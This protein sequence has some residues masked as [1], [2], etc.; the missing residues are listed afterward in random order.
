MS[1]I[2]RD[3]IFSTNKQKQRERSTTSP[4]AWFHYL[5]LLAANRLVIC[6][7]LPL[8]IAAICCYLSLVVI[9]CRYLPLTLSKISSPK[10][11][12]KCMLYYVFPTCPIIFKACG[13][14]GSTAE[15]LSLWFRHKKHSWVLERAPPRFSSCSL[16]GVLGMVFV[17][18]DFVF[19][20]VWDPSNHIWVLISFNS[21]YKLV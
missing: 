11:L 14:C 10:G 3:I 18:F 13:G 19:F 12:P 9:N 20:E 7:Y 1:K 6:R 17:N 4:R 2:S 16:I 21:L 15:A 8:S 5:P